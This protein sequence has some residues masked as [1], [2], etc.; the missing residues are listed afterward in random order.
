MFALILSIIILSY[1]PAPGQF[2]N[3]LPAVTDDPVLAAQ[4][5]ID[6]GSLVCLGAVGGSLTAQFSEPI[7]NSHDYDITVYGNAFENGSEPGVIFVSYD[8]N[9]NGLAD[10]QWY[11][12]A[13]SEYDRTIH[14]YSITYYRPASDTSNIRYRDSEG[15]EGF[16]PRNT[17][18][19][20]PYY[21]SWIAEDSIVLTGSLLPSNINDVKGDG[22]LV[23]LEAFEYGYADNASNSDLYPCSIKID[24][25]VDS[26]GNPANLPQVDFIRI[27]TGVLYT[28]ASNIGELSTEVSAIHPTATLTSLDDIPDNAIPEEFDAYTITGQFIGHYTIHDLP[29]LKTKL[30]IL[31]SQISILKGQNRTIKLMLK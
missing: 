12:I 13:G 28:N 14:N 10:D 4:T 29:E 6:R 3:M 22:S 24:W 25:A 18:H 2:I 1:N 8:E 17:F 16:I 15:N 26:L 7:I 9:G 11:E 21:P 19:Q 20:Q 30:S 31:N 27:Q 5:N 23:Y